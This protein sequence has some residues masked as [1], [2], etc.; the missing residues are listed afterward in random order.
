MTY[1]KSLC[2][3]LAVASASLMA[4]PAHALTI[5][6]GGQAATDGSGLT[7]NFVPASNTGLGAGY[8][9]ETFDFATKDVGDTPL[10]DPGNGTDISVAGAGC[11][12]NFYGQLTTTITGGGFGVQ[13]GSTPGVAAAPAGDNTCFGFGPRP[14]G[15]LPATVKVDYSNLLTGGDKISYLG[16]YY[17]SIDTYNDINIYDGNILLQTI[18]GASVLAAGGG[19]SGN[20]TLPGSNVYV[21]F[22]FAPGETFT[23]FE[24]VTTAVAFEVDN[25]VVGLTSRP[26]QVPEPG[27]LALFAAGLLGFVAARRLRKG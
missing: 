6:Y 17:G 15:T 26:N 2:L 8:F 9:I 11:S 22:A 3:S 27:S 19:L 5:T 24:F 20:Q 12:V 25:I 10:L 18:T 14:G 21:N 23:A 13:Q 16:L 7:S 4:L 1:C